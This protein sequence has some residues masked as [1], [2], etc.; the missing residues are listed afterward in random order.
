MHN[1]SFDDGGHANTKAILVNAS[2][3][4]LDLNGYWLNY[5]GSG[6]TFFGIYTNSS[7]LIVQNGTVNGFYYGVYFD[8]FGYYPIAKD[9]NVLNVS[10]SGAGIYVGGGNPYPFETVIDHCVITAASGASMAGIY[11]AGSDANIS[12]CRINGQNTGGEGIW[13]DGYGS[14]IIDS[15]NIMRGNYGIRVSSTV[16]YASI[17]GN[18]ITGANT[19]GIYVNATDATLDSNRIVHTTYGL[20]FP[21]GTTSK[22]LNTITAGCSTPFEC[23]SGACTSVGNNS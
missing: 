15:N 23:L 5:A 22:Y 21:T 20:Y 17:N 13:V 3:V 8:S 10:G 14:A 19:Y 16:S 4:T 18:S 2:N 6:T 12:N 1:L 7:N 9:V 11:L